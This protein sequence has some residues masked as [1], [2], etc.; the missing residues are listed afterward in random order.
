MRIAIFTDNFRLD[1]GGGTKVVY[2]TARGLKDLGHEVL[3]VT[4]RSVDNSLKREFKVFSL[5]S[6]R[7]PF[8]DKAEFVLP[9]L[10]L[11]KEIERFNPDIIHY[12]EP[13]TAGMVGVLVGRYI[14]RPVVGT[15][16]VDPMHISYHSLRLD[17][18]KIAKLL[19]GF[20]AKQSDAMVFVS[21]YQLKT[22]RPFLSENVFLKV[23]YPGIPG[24]F[25]S[26]GE[27]SFGK[28][29][30]TVT[31]LA[32]EK[33]LEFGLRVI[34]E[35]QRVVDF[36]YLVVGEGPERGKLEKLA[37]ELN[38]RVKFLGKVQREKLVELYSSS[39]I[40][41]LPSKYETFGLVFAEAM[42]CGL[43]V[44]CLNSGSA[45]E[46]VGEAG[47][48]CSENVSSVAESL[49]L[50]LSDRELWKRKS[51]LARERAEKFR[52]ANSVKEHLELYKEL[53]S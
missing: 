9:S 20:M 43:P 33:N 15:V 31:R 23:I 14:K 50:L 39:S 48:V 12:H 8:Y 46:V 49:K 13:F 5:P 35:V 28:R 22:Y 3:I 19:V 41:F 7:Y 26:S 1:M 16:H 6:F 36:E 40:F 34:S 44:V 18:G 51:V 45:P 17:N 4:G 27:A 30:I 38:V 21:S 47:F 24:Y 37:K 32:P 29:V 53:L 2:D 52:V 10:D 25:F 11:I 42:A